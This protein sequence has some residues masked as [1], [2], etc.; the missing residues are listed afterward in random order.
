MKGWSGLW[1]APLAHPD[2][3]ELSS[4]VLKDCTNPIGMASLGHLEA[5]AMKTTASSSPAI[6]SVDARVD[7]LYGGVWQAAKASTTVALPVGAWLSVS[8]DHAYHGSKGLGLAVG[9]HVTSIEYLSPIRTSSAKETLASQC[10]SLLEVV[11]CAPRLG[12]SQIQLRTLDGSQ[13]GHSTTGYRA[14][15]VGASATHA[16]VRTVASE[17]PMLTLGTADCSSSSWDQQRLQPNSRPLHGVANVERLLM[18]TPVIMP[19]SVQLKPMP[20]GALN[21]LKAV[22]GMEPDL[23]T[24]GGTGPF[25][26]ALHIRAVGL[27]F[28]DVLNVLGAY[29]GDPGPPGA[30]CAGVW[31]SNVT[32]TVVGEGA[33]GMAPGAL[34][35]MVSTNML[36]MPPKP[37][38]L[39]FEAVSGTPTVFVTVQIAIQQANGTTITQVS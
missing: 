20:R 32:G 4:H 24:S 15:A 16:V 36:M 29:P 34:A 31:A 26:G 17:C 21:G 13:V 27:N 7:V 25:S 28:R 5:R 30:D 14:H 18:T 22:P 23:W 9:A 35:S 11:Q 19:G 10:S 6:A 8:A 39:T 3:P 1:C 12:A 2:A 37:Q 33:F 38:A